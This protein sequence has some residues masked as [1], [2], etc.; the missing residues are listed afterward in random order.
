M[1]ESF[2]P[3]FFGEA[4]EAFPKRTIAYKHQGPS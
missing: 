1:N 3:E 4:N 2:D